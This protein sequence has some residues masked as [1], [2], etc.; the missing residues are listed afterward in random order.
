[1]GS[2]Q[3]ITLSQK[4]A[5][6]LSNSAIRNLYEKPVII[7]ITQPGEKDAYLKVSCPILRLQFDDIEYVGADKITNSPITLFNKEHARRIFEFINVTEPKTIITHCKAGVCRSAAVNAALSKILL[8][9]DDEFFKT[10]VP[11]MLVYKTILE[12]YFCDFIE[13]ANNKVP[14]IKSKYPFVYNTR[15]ESFNTIDK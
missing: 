7:S 13:S 9:E 11:N 5:E 3:F 2:I 10:K 6:A 14:S 1:M 12:Y 8:N 15:W 4:Q